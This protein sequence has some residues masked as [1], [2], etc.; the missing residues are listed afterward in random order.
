MSPRSRVS[1]PK[2]RN[3]KRRIAPE[4]F[5]PLEERHQLAKRIKYI[6]S[7]YHK[8]SPKDYDFP[9]VAPRPAT[10]LCD[11]HR[12]IRRTEALRLTRS[13]IRLGLFSDDF[14]KGDLPK[15][16]W[17][18]HQTPAGIEVYEARLGRDG[19]HGYLLDEGPARRIRRSA[20]PM[21]STVFSEWEKR[22]QS[23]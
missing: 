16:V 2:G 6:G 22:C 12:S 10:S 9:H 17:S 8:R 18:V 4:D 20:D 15:W 23:P 5:L 11:G 14:E 3:P 1:R 19:Y 13:G 21:C 7:P